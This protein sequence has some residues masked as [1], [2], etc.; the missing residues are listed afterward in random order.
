VGWL[1]EEFAA[2][3]ARPFAARGQVTDECIEIVKRLCAGGEVSFQGE[4]YRVQPVVSSPGSVQRPH[5]PIL[6]GGTSNAA[7]RRVARVADGWLSTSVRPDTVG[8]RLEV[9]KRLCETHDRR[10]DELSLCHK[11][12]I[13]IG[14]ARKAVDGSRDP[15][16]GSV[17]E[18][19]DDIRRFAD[20]GYGSFIV[21]YRGNDAEEQRRQLRTFAAD[22]MAKV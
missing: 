18:I 3:D 9:L 6:V 5:P 8:E 7:L 19:R 17:Q 1:A 20:H 2:L 11:F 10:W 16:T 4:Q 21:R 12:F 14:E 15:G 13:N 22:I